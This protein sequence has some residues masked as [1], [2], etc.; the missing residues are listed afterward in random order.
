MQIDSK[1]TTKSQNNE[2]EYGFRS[3]SMKLAAQDITSLPQLPVKEFARRTSQQGQKSQEPQTQ[4]L[5][6]HLLQ[7]LDSKETAIRKVG[8]DIVVLRGT[9]E[10]QAKEIGRL[11]YE[12]EENNLKTSRIIHSFDL[13]ALEAPELVR[14]YSVLSA[15]LETVMSSHRDLRTNY[16]QCM[17]ELEQKR[18]V[19]KRM[20]QLEL[21]HMAQQALLL[22]L[23]S[24]SRE[25]DKLKRVIEKQ[26]EVICLLEQKIQSKGVIAHASLA[27]LNGDQKND[28]FGNNKTNW[29]DSSKKLKIESQDQLSSSESSDVFLLK[30]EAQK[31]RAR[32]QALEEE[33]INSSRKFGVQIRDL[34][35]KL[36]TSNG[37]SIQS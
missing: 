7:E 6:D 4:A 14:R 36:R 17:L 2:I 19:G 16:E 34:K 18:I 8:R 29:K 31:A 35:M 28:S 37:Y 21:A 13:E 27:Q 3:P 1:T 24:G 5:I 10:A 32:I 30:L 26:E 33:L 22:E 25:T 9:N 15:K 11:K 23:Q 20:Q 12:L